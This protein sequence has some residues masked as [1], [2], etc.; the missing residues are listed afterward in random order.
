MQVLVT[1]CHGERLGKVPGFLVG[2]LF[3]VALS[4]CTPTELSEDPY[5]SRIK[6][7]SPPIDA[8]DWTQQ[9][10]SQRAGD[11]AQ[12]VECLPGMHAS[13]CLTPSSA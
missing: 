11:V 7:C 5:L 3:P 4:D 9:K 13:T 1:M 6:V 12:L 8:T 10:C 2:V